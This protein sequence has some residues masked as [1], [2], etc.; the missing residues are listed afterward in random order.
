CSTVPDVTSM[1]NSSSWSRN[2]SASNS[3]AWEER[4]RGAELDGIA[5]NVSR[6]LKLQQ[7]DSWSREP[8]LDMNVCR[9]QQEVSPPPRASAVAAL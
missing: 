3:G 2:S 1:R 9:T 6:N 5:H 7:R 4:W 8:A